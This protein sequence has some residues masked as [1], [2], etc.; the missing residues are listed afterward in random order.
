M[1]AFEQ[2]Q[3]NLSIIEDEVLKA[4]HLVPWDRTENGAWGSGLVFSGSI[5][6]SWERW[7][8]QFEQFLQDKPSGFSGRIVEALAQADHAVK[9]RLNPHG[10]TE[11]RWKVIFAYESAFRELRRRIG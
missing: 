4:V 6:A 10:A 7:R 8:K 11:T 1:G 3:R 2:L 5:S 9:F